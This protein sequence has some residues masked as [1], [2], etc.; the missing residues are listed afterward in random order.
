MFPRPA[1]G[2]L[3]V[4]AAGTRLL[5]YNVSLTFTRLARR[6]GLAAA[7]AAAVQGRMI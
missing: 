5:N 4:S 2:A 7:P 1:S 6:A 3:L